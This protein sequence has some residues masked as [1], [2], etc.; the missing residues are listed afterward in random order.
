MKLEIRNLA[1]IESAD[2][3]LDGITMI[4]GPNDSGKSTCGKVLCTVANAFSQLEK[5]G[6]EIRVGRIRDII[7]GNYNLPPWL[8]YYDRFTK[9]VNA[10]LDGEISAQDF[11]NLLSKSQT[12]AS[13]INLGPVDNHDLLEKLEAVRLL[14]EHAVQCEAIVRSFNSAFNG[15]YLPLHKVKTTGKTDTRVS[16]LRGDNGRIDIH[17]REMSS[18]FKSNF[19]LSCNSWLLDNPDLLSYMGQHDPLLARNQFE[20][21]LVSSLNESR[22]KATLEPVS[23]A[24]DA[25]L[26]K[27][28]M[29]EVRTYLDSADIG[30]LAFDKEMGFVL[31]RKN[32]KAPIR[33]ANVSMGGK[34]IAMLKI[35]LE[36]NLLHE[37][38]FLVLDEP[39]IHLHPQWQILYARAI[40]N[41]NR[42]LGVNVLL[43]THSPDFIQ[44][45]R[46]FSIQSNV[47]FNA[48]LSTAKERVVLEP[49][50]EKDHDRLFSGF[51]QS[52]DELETLAEEM[53]YRS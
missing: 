39:E 24:L 23:G 52:V 15:Q 26:Q 28:K 17:L 8:S 43:T 38:D 35:L 37:G 42:V 7:W 41:L 1:K 36:S 10:Y 53:G 20:W 3:E 49:I 2:I 27:R 19:T 12:Q 25:A 46:L 30:E 11:G 4:A 50:P 29:A 34:S 40:A 45:M 13:R 33:I 14:D 47:K 21:S 32:L 31:R 18:E 6:R 5:N 48:Y 22:R 9:S 16:L 44:A 51:A